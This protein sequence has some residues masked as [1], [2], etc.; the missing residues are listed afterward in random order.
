MS[1]IATK[2]GADTVRVS[3]DWGQASDQ[4]MGDL[5]GGY[6]VADF[7]HSPRA[8]LRMALEQCARLEE[9]EGVE[10]DA[11]VDEAMRGAKEEM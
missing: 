1:T 2:W 8:A 4:I 10:A 5:E 11:L 7:G 9:L 6:Q 3:A